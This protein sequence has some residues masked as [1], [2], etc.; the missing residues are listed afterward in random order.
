ML[1]AM[2]KLGVL[3][4]V[5]S[6][7]LGLGCC[8]PQVFGPL[9]GILFAG[10]ILDRV[11]LEWQLPLLYGSLAVALVGFGLGWRRHRGV[12]PL[13]LFLPGA[14]AVLYP[15][16]VALD[17]SVLKILIWLGFGLL[18]AAA[19]WDGWLSFQARRCR[20][21]LPRSEALQ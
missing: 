1:G 2:G 13:L 15:L 12:A 16:H 20:R 11:P 18:L 6:A 17:V 19:V 5:A 7:A 3:G 14:A 8:A 9:A 4:T 10:G 21:A